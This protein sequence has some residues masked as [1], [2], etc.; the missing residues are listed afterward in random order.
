MQND[1][2]AIFF[3]I[4]NTL[5]FL[6]KDEEHQNHIREQI[7]SLTGFDHTVDDLCEILETRYKVYRKWAFSTLIEAS[8]EDLWT[9]W[10]LPDYPKEKINPIAGELTTLFRQI[11]GKRIFVQDGKYVI[12]ELYIRGYSLGI[13]SNLISRNEIPD[14]LREEG[15]QKHFQ[16]VVLSSVF[17]KRKPSPEIYQEAVKLVGVDPKNCAY[18]GDN[19]NRDVEGARL[20]GFNT[21]ILLQNEQ[22]PFNEADFDKNKPD[23]VIHQFREL[24]NLFPEIQ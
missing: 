19:P 10:L 11:N 3:D 21:V 24:L 13:I 18:I 16:A 5:R 6:V 20:A 23:Y 1:I 12:N 22:D 2:N 14:W 17:G 9:K 8:E 15:L 4:G 7:K